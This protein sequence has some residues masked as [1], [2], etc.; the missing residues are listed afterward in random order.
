MREVEA[1]F[2][3]SPDSLGQIIILKVVMEDDVVAH[4][5]DLRVIERT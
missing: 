2:A 3:G 5:R 1:D 4:L